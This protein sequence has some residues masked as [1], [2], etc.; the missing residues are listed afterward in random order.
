LQHMQVLRI[1]DTRSLEE[2]RSIIA[3]LYDPQAV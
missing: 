1:Y 2:Q 3:Q